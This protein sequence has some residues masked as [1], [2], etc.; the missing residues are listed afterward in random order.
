MLNSRKIK[1]PDIIVKLTGRDGNAFSILGAVTN[2]LR[3]GGAP[4]KEIDEYFEEAQ[5]GDY[6]H[7]LRT[8]MQWVNVE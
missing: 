4:E 3:H 6:D 2:A 7:L 1:Y 5:S 8:T